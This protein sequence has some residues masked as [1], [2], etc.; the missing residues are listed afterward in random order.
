[1]LE[2]QCAH[3]GEQ[4]HYS[5]QKFLSEETQQ[6]KPLENRPLKPPFLYITSAPKL[7]SLLPSLQSSPKTGKPPIFSLILLSQEAEDLQV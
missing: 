3:L 4:T 6:N 7:F 2:L 1:M 5:S